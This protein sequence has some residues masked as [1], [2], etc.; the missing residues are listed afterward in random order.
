MS[1]PHRLWGGRPL[2]RTPRVAPPEHGLWAFVVLA[3]GVEL[4]KSFLHDQL[5]RCALGEV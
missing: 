1:W 3:E 4:P 5:D 2:E